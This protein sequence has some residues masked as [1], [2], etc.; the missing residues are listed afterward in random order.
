MP[1]CPIDGDVEA[2]T[3]AALAAVSV[4]VLVVVVVA[5][6]NAAVTPVGKPRRQRD[7]SAESSLRR[8]RKVAAPVPPSAKFTLA[9]EED[10]LKPGSGRDGQRYGRLR[11][12]R[13]RRSRDRHRRGTDRGATQLP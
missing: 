8:D 1:E 10:S 6:L 13:A 2:L 3:A 12:K 4:N 9:A 11:G 5:G 7:R